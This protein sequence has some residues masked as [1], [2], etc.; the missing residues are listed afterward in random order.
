MIFLEDRDG[1]IFYLSTECE[2]AWSTNNG[3]LL[4]E[5]ITGNG[6]RHTDRH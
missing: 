2:Q 6:D 1:G 3:D 5:G 4:S